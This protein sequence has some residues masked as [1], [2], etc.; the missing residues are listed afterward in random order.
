MDDTL[1]RNLCCDVTNE[2]LFSVPFPTSVSSFLGKQTSSLKCRQLHNYH[3]AR[4]NT[5]V[6]ANMQTHVQIALL[7]L[8]VKIST[9]LAYR[10]CVDC[11]ATLKSDL[12]NASCDRSLSCDGL[13]SLSTMVTC[14]S[15]ILLYSP[16]IQLDFTVQLQDIANVT[17]TSE[18]GS[19]VRCNSGSRSTGFKFLNARNIRIENVHFESCGVAHQVHYKK[20]YYYTLL[21]EVCHNISLDK[22]HVIINANQSGI[23]FQNSGGEITLSNCSLTTTKCTNRSGNGIVLYASNSSQTGRYY[24]NCCKFQG[25]R[26]LGSNANE[27]GAIHIM[28]IKGSLSNSVHINKCIFDDNAAV[29]GGAVKIDLMDSA[30]NNTINFYATKFL[31][32]VARNRGGA[33]QLRTERGRTDRNGK[34]SV[35][36][37]DCFLHNNVAVIGSAVAVFET[38]K[39]S[40]TVIEFNS[41]MI[42]GNMAR[43]FIHKQT[44]NRYNGVGALYA[45]RT[46]LQFAGH[47]KLV[48]N[49]GSSIMLKDSSL[50]ILSSCSTHFINN[51]GLNGGAITMCDGCTLS[52][53]VNTTTTFINNSASMKGGA[54]YAV[55]Q[56]SSI[57]YLISSSKTCLFVFEYPYQTKMAFQDNAAGENVGNDVYSSTFARCCSANTYIPCL[58]I[59]FLSSLLSRT[60]RLNTPGVK[61]L[62]IAETEIFQVIPGKEDELPIALMDELDQ[63][64]HVHHCEAVVLEGNITFANG[65][66]SIQIL[67]CA[68]IKLYGRP[69]EQAQLSITLP[70]T[71]NM[72]ARLSAVLLE[73]PPGFVWDSSSKT[74]ECSVSGPSNQIYPGIIKCDY[75]EKRAHVRQWYW[76]GYDRDENE[77]E[78]SLISSNYPQFQLFNTSL[79][80]PKASRKEL[81]R[82]FCKA[83]HRSGIL[84]GKCIENFT[85]LYHHSDHV[86]YEETYYCKFGLL[87]YILSELLPVTILF[88]IVIALDI[89]FT[90][91]G[92]NSFIFFAQ[93]VVSMRLQGLASS[94]SPESTVAVGTLVVYKMLN[95]DFFSIH[96]L[97]FCLWKG[98]S[99]LDVLA[100]KYVTITYSLFLV[101]CFVLALQKCCVPRC[102]KKFFRPVVR[103]RKK[104]FGQSVVHGISSFFAMCF[105]QCAFVSVGILTISFIKGKRDFGYMRFKRRVVYYNGELEYFNS[106]H[107]LYAIPAL[108]FETF[109]LVPPTLL[110]I[111]PL[112]YKVFKA[113][114]VKENHVTVCCKVIPL[115]KLRPLFDSIQSSF[116]DKYRFF[117]GLYFFY[118]L[119]P[120]IIFALFKSSTFY[121][122][123][124][125]VLIFILLTHCLC[126]PYKENSHNK[127]DTCLL[128]NLLFINTLSCWKY[129]AIVKLYGHYDQEEI[130]VISVL[131][132][133]LVLLPLLCLVV[134]A[135]YY[136]IRKKIKSCK[137]AQRGFT[138]LDSKVFELAAL[139]RNSLDC[140]GEFRAAYVDASQYT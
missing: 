1:L 11:P 39:K 109:F 96:K 41:C 10:I 97:S 84:C 108:F 128:I 103:R 127:I 15:S 137:N 75:M 54:I 140:S 12:N 34:N 105:A 121:T 88:T 32:N 60:N 85:T 5:F 25:I 35:K 63:Q 86:C 42:I 133:I 2:G 87:F 23:A 69:G 123:L 7:W 116:K 114:H 117:A 13:R 90:S 82:F 56:T 125:I 29:Y 38:G 94:Q 122:V 99:S 131:Q 129:I 53:G 135:L 104:T 102:L 19:Y 40:G 22:V 16:I 134:Y 44:T 107:L 136:L 126:Q 55:R 115:E 45:K 9:A 3:S 70:G 50:I 61:F 76:V 120:P 58:K 36:W 124:E 21:F 51:T 111:Y 49:N 81:D 80:P 17:I 79:M 71:Q 106:K 26:A 67:D 52:M 4:V 57:E 98:A 92:I 110:V 132:P 130:E 93:F 89:S 37:F 66:E 47:M 95:L 112:C 83:Q 62:I 48:A 101:L 72:V 43:S 78:D 139:D 31:N 68:K 59:P 24:F 46:T 30:V 27:G 77:S 91:G 64:L 100:V 28:F 65:S 20:S 18:N 138:E 14:N 113:F 73:C 33:V 74:C 118:R 8:V 6:T 119:L